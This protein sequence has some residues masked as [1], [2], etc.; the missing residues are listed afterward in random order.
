MFF[1]KLLITNA[2]IVSCV[3]IGKRLPTLAGLIAA[4]PLTSLL[5]L[6][7]LYTDNPGDL[8]SLAKYCGGVLWGIIPTM[9]FFAVALFCLRRQ[10]SLPLALS[11]SFAVW[12]A[13]AALHQ[14]FLR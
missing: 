13:G 14:W 1:F 11:L 4:M 9:L 2:V 6:I 8:R 7:W 5:V 10:I 12:L 3:L